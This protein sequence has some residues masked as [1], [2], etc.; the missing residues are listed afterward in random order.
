M[1]KKEKD[2]RKKRGANERKGAARKKSSRTYCQ[3][4]P[5]LYYFLGCPSTESY[6]A[7]SRPRCL[8]DVIITIRKSPYQEGAMRKTKLGQNAFQIPVYVS[9]IGFNQRLLALFS[10]YVQLFYRI[11][12]REPVKVMILSCLNEKYTFLGDLG[13]TFNLVNFSKN[14]L[15]V[16]AR[17]F[18]TNDVVS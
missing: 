3:H 12:H 2:Y 17:L 15:A 14:T 11:A 13:Y 1:K 18:K 16:R 9:W 10:I 4:N 6:P 8:K 5:L 7:P